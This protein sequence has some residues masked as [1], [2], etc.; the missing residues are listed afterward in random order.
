MKVIN[1]LRKLRDQF[2]SDER[3]VWKWLELSVD[4]SGAYDIEYKYSM[5]PLTEEMLGDDIL[6]SAQKLRF[7]S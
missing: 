4:S 2:S 3:E 1:V 6:P 7:K 5:P